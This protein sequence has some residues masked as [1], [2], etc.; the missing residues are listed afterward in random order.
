MDEQQQNNI[1]Q[2]YSNGDGT[3][4]QSGGQTYY[5][6]APYGSGSTPDYTQQGTVYVESV[7][8]QK[9]D[10]PAQSIIGLILGIASITLGCCYGIGAL[11]GIPGI[12]LSII[13]NKNKKTGIGTAGLVTSII[14]VVISVIM[15]I[16][17]VLG[18]AAVLS[19]P[20][21]WTTY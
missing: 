6:R 5:Q 3:G 15:I 19:D 1:P 16:C 4:P 11:A 8:P 9:D 12:I 17:V 10:T 7:Q 13:G 21:A 14:G 18:V 2:Q 20:S